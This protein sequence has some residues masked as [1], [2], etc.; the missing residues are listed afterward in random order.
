MRSVGAREFKNR[1]GRYIRAVQTGESLL[2]VKR[3]APVAKVIPA[4]DAPDTE[5]P[6]MKRLKELEAQGKIRLG[7]GRFRKFRPIRIKGKLLS[8]TIIENRR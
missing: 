2:L 4:D 1:M 6:V 8:Q 3:G 5:S 7:T